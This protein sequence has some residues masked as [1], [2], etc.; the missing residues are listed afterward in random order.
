MATAFA[1][2]ASSTPYG[3][4]FFDSIEAG[5]LAS[6]RV[7]VPIVKLIVPFR[8]VVDVGCGRGVWLRVFQENGA[9]EI[10]GLDGDY[11]D[12]SKLAISNSSFRSRDLVR[13]FSVPRDY[14]LA[15]CLEVGEHLPASV[16]GRLVK[17]LTELAPVVLFSAAIPGQGGTRHI[18][19]QWPRFWEGQFNALGY[20]RI[21]AIRPRIWC[22]NDV[23][24]WFRQNCFLYAS[25]QGL[26]NNEVL[27]REHE[28]CSSIPFQLIREDILNLNLSLRGTLGRLPGQ[29]V[30]WILQR[31][32][33][34]Q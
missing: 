16:A 7:V 4:D 31:V 27:R 22:E 25:E 10:L 15:V 18:N 3:G 5:S 11:V 33:F 26:R 29:I 13:D 32:G 21:D 1:A 19:E 12:R 2:A 8:S 34:C 23:S 9:E 20:S 14:D 17:M 28:K 6:A 30:R 24:W